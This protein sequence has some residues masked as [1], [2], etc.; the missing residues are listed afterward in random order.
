MSG[1]G[2]GRGGQVILTGDTQMAA[3]GAAATTMQGNLDAMD[4]AYGG[5][6]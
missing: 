4:Y 5:G 6:F 1:T 3:R 2:K